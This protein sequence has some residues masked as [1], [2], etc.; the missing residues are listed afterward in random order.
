MLVGLPDMEQTGIHTGT[1]RVDFNSM[2]RANE[3]ELLEVRVVLKPSIPTGRLGT[4][5]VPFSCAGRFPLT[6]YNTAS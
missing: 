2:D 1:K 5:M 6:G 3:M 4:D